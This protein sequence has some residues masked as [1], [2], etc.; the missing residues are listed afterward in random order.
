MQLLPLAATH[1]EATLVTVLLQLGII[2]AVARLFGLLFKKL[3]QPV[4]AGEIAAGVVLGPSVFGKLEVLAG[5]SNH[6]VSR[7]IFDPAVADVFGVLSQLGL[8]LLLFLVGMEFDFSHL[9]RSHKSALA[10][11]ITGVVIPFALGWQLAR[12]IHPQVEGVEKGGVMVPVDAHGFAL[13]MG[14]AMAIT[15]LPVLARMMMEF[16]VTRTRI[17]TVTIS[18]AAIDDATGWI[19]LAAVSAMVKAQ[20]QPL[21][22]LRMV[23]L[24][25]AFAGGMLL[26]VRPV[27]VRWI[28]WS[29]KRGHGELGLNA[30]AILLIVIFLCSIAT[31]LIGIFAIFG[32]FTLGAVL[33]DQAVFR[34]AVTRELRNFVMVFFL[35]IFFTY[36]GLRT[37]IGT[38]G[39]ATMWMLAAAVCAVAIVG[40]FGGCTLAA[41]A[42]GLSWRDSLC[43]GSLMNTRGLMELVVINVGYDLG[44]IPRSVYCMLV[45]M[46][47]VTTYMTAPLLQA[48]KRGTELEA[49]MRASRFGRRSAD[50][51]PV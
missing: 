13:F 28:A 19:L 43:I 49:P 44:I 14:T 35:P 23:G 20:Y 33:S 42:S 31:S 11:S 12:W 39:S 34:E 37:D 21:E 6:E 46:A 4:V 17:G 16:N 50:G 26:V 9:K 45:I 36:T 25:V 47:M 1:H 22:T 10:I 38:L 3:G 7:A 27:L 18:A 24:T 5:Y 15:A 48:F 41:K 51:L 2:V 29:L 40:K 32:A 8:I 30:M